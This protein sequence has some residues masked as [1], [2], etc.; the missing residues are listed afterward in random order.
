[1]MLARTIVLTGDPRDLAALAE[2]AA[3]PIT[4]GRG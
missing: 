1:M 4:I 3:R 2:H